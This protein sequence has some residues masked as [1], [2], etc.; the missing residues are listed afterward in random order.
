VEDEPGGD[1]A[2]GQLGSIDHYGAVNIGM[3]QRAVA[4]VAGRDQETAP[5]IVHEVLHSHGDRN[6]KNEKQDHRHR[7]DLDGAVIC[8]DRYHIPRIRLL[9]R[10]W[11]RA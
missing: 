6:E 3:P 10:L 4:T 7:H 2:V 9:L 11:S 8:S 1:A 5:A